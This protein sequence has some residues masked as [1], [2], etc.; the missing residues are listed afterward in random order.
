MGFGVF[1]S[2]FRIWGSGFRVWVV[3]F[4]DLGV[5]FWGFGFRVSGAGIILKGL[6]RVGLGVGFGVCHLG[7]GAL[8]LDLCSV[9]FGAYE[10][11]GRPSGWLIL[12][13]EGR[14]GGR[15]GGLGG[16]REGE[17]EGGE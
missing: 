9:G 14:E 7:S 4:R 5:R 13:R 15:E 8:A 17:R 10:R 16:G 3:V 6:R 2:G 12:M 1:G 11:C